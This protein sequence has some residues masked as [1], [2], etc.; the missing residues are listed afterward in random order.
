MLVHSAFYQFTHI[1]NPENLVQW[2][3]TIGDGIQGS[4]LVA[5]EGINATVAGSPSNIE[6]FE[7]L[8]R[9]QSMF[10]NMQFKNSACTTAPYGLLRIHIKPEIVQMGVERV[11]SVNH[12]PNAVSPQQWAKLIEQDNIVLLDNRNRFEFDLGHF[13]GAINPNV[14]HFKDFPNYVEHNL[15]AWKAAGKTIAMY[16]TGGIRCDKTSAWLSGQGVDSIVLDGGI[17]NFFAQEVDS[18]LF[19]GE[20]FVF[21]NRLALNKRLEQTQTTP[22]QVFAN[23]PDAAWRIARA[24]KLLA[25]AATPELKSVEKTYRSKVVT[26]PGTHLNMLDFFVDRFNHVKKQDWQH[27]FSL[28]E[29]TDQNGKVIQADS[30]FHANV[31]LSYNRAIAN[32]RLIPFQSSIIFEDE[33]I[34]VADKPHFLSVA[35]SGDQVAETLLMRLRQQLN[36]PSLSPAH[37]IDRDTAG[38]VLFTKQK[39]HRGLYQN[40]FRDRFIHKVYSAVAAYKPELTFPMQIHNRLERSAEHF[41]QAASTPG[42]PNAQTLVELHEHNL[43]WALYRLT[44]ST[45]Q[46]HQLRVHMHELGLPIVNDEIYPKLQPEVIDDDQ[47]WAERYQRP[48]QLLAKE[49]R[50]TDPFTQESRHFVSRF[51]LHLPVKN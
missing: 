27:R 2:L 37:R 26:T 40:L 25:A 31:T 33:L 20:C 9:Q 17:L 3:H 5:S 16:C 48:L 19:D 50:F 46:R 39:A 35:P 10:E 44:P 11:D 36:C 43:Q 7:G 45:G 8:I 49:L 21:D 24:K 18:P 28:G 1:S 15:P 32:E 6:R 12:R 38:L 4:I 22:E 14:S 41:M 29:I 23:E 34:V 30:P 51:N 42:I 47:A 13:K